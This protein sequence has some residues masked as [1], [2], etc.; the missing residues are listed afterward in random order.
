[1]GNPCSNIIDIELKK[2]EDIDNILSILKEVFNN[3]I[4]EDEI[5]GGHKN[6]R[7][8][9]DSNWHPL[10]EETI[11]ISQG[12][13][14]LKITN[15]FEENSTGLYGTIKFINGEEIKNVCTYDDENK[16]ITYYFLEIYNESNKV[17]HTEG[18]DSEFELREKL[19]A[20]PEETKYSI[21]QSE[22]EMKGRVNKYKGDQNE[23]N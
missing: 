23:R 14:D 19:L 17:V 7:Y 18:N 22:R 11:K 13:P 6:V 9:V 10:I 3:D 8:S 15:Q 1:M 20:Y 21:W 5:E 16:Q 4:T 12:L 2:E